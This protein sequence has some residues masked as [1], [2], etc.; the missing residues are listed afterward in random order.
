MSCLFFRRPFLGRVLVLILV[1]LL[2]PARL[3]T[4]P[5]A[6]P[7][8]ENHK[9]EPELANKGHEVAFICEC[10]R[11]FS[12]LSECAFT[13]LRNV[14]VINQNELEMENWF[15]ISSLSGSHGCGLFHS[16]GEKRAMT[17]RVKLTNHQESSLT[18]IFSFF[19]SFSSTDLRLHDRPGIS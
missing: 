6:F 8:D 17:N 12:D 11:N 5:A 14:P 15:S 19:I 3:R 9:G 1:Q 13:C 2:R 10:F 16:Y 4:T 7:A 18:L